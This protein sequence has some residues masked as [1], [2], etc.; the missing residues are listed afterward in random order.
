MTS[1]ISL[2]R[3]LLTRLLGL[4]LPIVLGG[5][6]VHWYFQRRLLAA[7]FDESLVEKATILATLVT[8][9]GED[10][11]LEFAD[12]FMPHYS[13]EV[14]PHAFQVWYPDGR[15]LE[16]SYSLRGEDLPFRHGPLGDPS[17]FETTLA[18]GA[19]L[20]CVGVEFPARLGNDPDLPSGPP[21]IIAVGAEAAQLEEALRQGYLEVAITGIV[22][23]VGI[24][25]FVLLALR[26]G[27]RLL[28]RIVKEVEGIT[29]GSLERPLDESRAPE[30][31][32]PIL[33]SLNRSR[34]TLRGFV[35]R[36]RRFT[37]DVAH[38]LRTPI[39][40][41]R[42]A[43]DIALRWPDEES[44]N[45]LGID[46]RDIALQMGSLVESLLELATIEA[47][48]IREEGV[49][50]DLREVVDLVVHHAGRN[51]AGSRE[52][53]LD[54]PGSLP[55]DSRPELWEVAARN[56]V[57]NAV[58][59][60]PPGARIQVLLR[61]HGRGASLAVSNPTQS[62]DPESLARCTERL[63]RASRDPND[64]NHFGLGLSIVQAACGKLGHRLSV[65][66]EA[67]VFHAT[68]SPEAGGPAEEA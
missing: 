2:H 64:P 56:L 31:I 38:E 37:A 48:G 3:F 7:Q 15:S 54:A 16:R 18:S 40:E 60:S 9:H 49:A 1:G 20:R 14:R 17:V 68:I 34:E 50:M 4:V 6:A 43:A 29:P 10:M 62:I 51:H 63:W 58:S 61:R 21:V 52:I 66:L 65:R 41:L 39:A 26:R 55:L 67:G 59:Y 22:S 33:A 8:A 47:D 13:R 27:V 42:S 28:D 35:E 12:E 19:R 11:K 53:A 23:V 32:R 36:E 24:S 57:D 46:A 30:E 44:R 45:R 5:M 25:I